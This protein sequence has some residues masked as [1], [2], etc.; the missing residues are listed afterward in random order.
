V[1][2]TLLIAL[3]FADA[4]TVA[5]KDAELSAWLNGRIAEWK[6]K[7]AERKLDEIGWADDVRQARKLSAKFGR[8]VM[9]FTMD[10][11]F[12]IGRC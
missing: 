10:G 1:I 8:P 3:A 12:Q 2:S 9:L 6:P 7:P 11:R 4:P 5:P